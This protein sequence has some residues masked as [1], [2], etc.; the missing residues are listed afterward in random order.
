M[1]L[2][3]VAVIFFMFVPGSLDSLL[4]MLPVLMVDAEQ[5]PTE[6]LPT[7][8]VEEIPVIEDQTLPPQI[9]TGNGPAPPLIQI[10][11]GPDAGG[12]SS[13][14]PAFLALVACALVAFL[15]SRV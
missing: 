1:R 4:Y 6:V 2:C 5:M 8:A 15:S 7:T 9:I 10:L 3:C 11:N 13:T 14:R 12:V